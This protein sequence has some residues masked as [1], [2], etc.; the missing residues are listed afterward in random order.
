M[1]S[2]KIAKSTCNSKVQGILAGAIYANSVVT[3]SAEAS[4][5]LARNLTAYNFKYG[6]KTITLGAAS[7][8]SSVLGVL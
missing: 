4:K 6:A 8:M 7:S 5:L 3:G 1:T 2:G